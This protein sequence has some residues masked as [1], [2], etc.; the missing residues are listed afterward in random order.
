MEDENGWWLALAGSSYGRSVETVKFYLS[1]AQ[2]KIPVFVYDGKEIADMLAGHD[3]IGIVPEGVTPRY[4]SPYFPGEKKMLQ[5]MNLPDEETE[6][7]IEA[8]VWY[9]IDE[10]K[11]A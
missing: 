8:A 1:L 6:A 11:L 10:V 5:Y 7:V 2:R 3:W 9:P 4:C